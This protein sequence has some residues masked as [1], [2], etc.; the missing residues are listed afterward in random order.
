MFQWRK[1]DDVSSSV[2][3]FIFS[4][5]DDTHKKQDVFEQGASKRL[6]VCSR[7]HVSTWKI[8]GQRDHSMCVK[9]IRMLCHLNSLQ[10]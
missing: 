3:F 6:Q 9:D 7:F 10:H 8:L 1:L 4:A 5:P 2:P